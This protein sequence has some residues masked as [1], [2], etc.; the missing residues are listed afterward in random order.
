MNGG[1]T[2][3]A[4][5][6]SE[7]QSVSSLTEV[8]EAEA[9]SDS[10]GVPESESEPVDATEPEVAEYV[11][12]SRGRRAAGTLNREAGAEKTRRT[13]VVATEVETVS[14]SERAFCGTC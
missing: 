2:V 13:T 6:E 1:W 12:V 3:L 4:E 11:P 10:A 8:V 7:S 9:G 14:V 5:S